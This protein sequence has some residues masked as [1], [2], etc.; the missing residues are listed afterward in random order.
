MTR[1]WCTQCLTRLHVGCTCSLTSPNG[2]TRP[3]E[4]GFC[5]R[6]S[7]HLPPPPS[8]GERYSTTYWTGG[9][10]PRYKPSPRLYTSF[11]RK[12]KSLLYRHI[13]GRLKSLETLYPLGDVH[14]LEM[15]LK[16][17]V[18]KSQFFIPYLVLQQVISLPFCRSPTWKRCF[19]VGSSP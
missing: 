4:T 17:L 1:T 6:V 2:T 19:S 14:L 9:F 7:T 12:S 15:F 3:S 16:A 8:S 11:D 13:H 18:L 10:N 5:I